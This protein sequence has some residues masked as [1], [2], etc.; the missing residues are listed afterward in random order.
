MIWPVGW[1]EICLQNHPYKAWFFVK[2]NCPNSYSVHR[3][4]GLTYDGGPAASTLL[5][6]IHLLSVPAIFSWISPCTTRFLIHN[7]R[8]LS[9]YLNERFPTI[10]ASC[11]FKFL[12][13]AVPL[14][15]WKILWEIWFSDCNVCFIIVFKRLHNQHKKE[16]AWN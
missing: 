13:I 10:F 3:L 8:R 15:L 14:K 1:I 6:F 5:S 9:I 11:H 12:P 16:V 7:M 4:A 2:C